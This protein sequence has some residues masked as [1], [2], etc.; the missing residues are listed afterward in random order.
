M[1]GRVVTPSLCFAFKCVSGVSET[2]GPAAGPAKGK[3]CVTGDSVRSGAE[4]VDTRKEQLF[5][6]DFLVGVTINYC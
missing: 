2:R 5:P 3:M 1:K 6:P 4:Q